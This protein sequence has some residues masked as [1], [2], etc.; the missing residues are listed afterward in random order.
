MHGG[1]DHKSCLSFQRVAHACEGYGASGGASI[2]R[3]NAI[4]QRMQDKAPSAE[5]LNR[6]PIDIHVHAVGNGSDGSGCWLRIT[7]WRRP[8]AELMVR[9]IG[10][11]PSALTGNLEGILETH[12]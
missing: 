10:L 6:K 9:H 8:F 11:T 3:R 12:L 1:P 4:L 5:A 7:P 2:S